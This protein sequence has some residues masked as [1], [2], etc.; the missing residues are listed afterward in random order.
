MKLKQGLLLEGTRV[1]L[2]LSHQR[3]VRSSSSRLRNLLHCRE[4]E[5][6]RGGG[7]VL[8]AATL[9]PGSWGSF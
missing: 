3:W 2:H 1:W 7:L 8:L 5:E 6:E 9:C 4:E